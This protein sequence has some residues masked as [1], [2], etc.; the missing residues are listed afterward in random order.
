MQRTWFCSAGKALPAGKQSLDAV[1]FTG[2]KLILLTGDYSFFS[3]PVE[4]NG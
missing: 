4:F 2:I 3:A 1:L